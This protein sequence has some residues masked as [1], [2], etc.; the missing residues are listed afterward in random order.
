[1][2]SGW[3]LEQRWAGWAQPVYSSGHTWQRGHYL[4]Q[5]WE[6]GYFFFPRLHSSSLVFPPVDCVFC[7]RA[8]LSLV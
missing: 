2:G 7:G 8:R 1:M 5:T 3:G 6:G 4:E